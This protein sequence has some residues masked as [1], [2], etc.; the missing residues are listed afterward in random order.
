MKYRVTKLKGKDLK[1]GDLFSSMGK[2]YWG[3]HNAMREIAIGEKVYIRTDVK[4]PKSQ[5][6]ETVYKIEVEKND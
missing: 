2:I 3:Q 6:E 1:V 4:L 5:K